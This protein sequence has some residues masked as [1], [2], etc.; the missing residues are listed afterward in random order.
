[1][2]KRKTTNVQ[3]PLTPEQLA[4]LDYICSD[5]D[6]ERAYSRAETMRYALQKLASSYDLEWPDNLAPH[7]DFSR[8]R[9]KR[10]PIEEAKDE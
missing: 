10:W 3:V 6:P 9:A 8:A 5:T 2:S 1:M 7:G 4:V